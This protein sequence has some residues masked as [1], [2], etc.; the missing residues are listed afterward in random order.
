MSS[1]PNRA[2]AERLLAIAERLLRGQDFNGSRDFAVLAQENDPILDG[3]DQILAVADVLMASQKK[4][5]NHPDWYAILQV[6][7][8]SDD[9]EL[10]KRQYRRL[11]L[12]LHPDKNSFPFADSAFHLVSDAWKLLSDVQKKSI[13][14][15]E[16]GV[17]MFSKVDLVPVV[18]S[19]S[20]RD[21]FKKLPVRRGEKKKKNEEEEEEKKEKEK[22]KEQDTF[23]TVCPYCYNLYQYQKIYQDCC[24]KCQKCERAFHGVVIWPVPQMVPGKDAYYCCKAFFPFN[25]PPSADP[26]YQDPEA[27]KKMEATP[28]AAAPTKKRGRSRKR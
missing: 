3:S 5:N 12:L 9:L 15:N 21:S 22:E 8:R 18:E 7:R 24:L 11:T 13:Y 17:S 23:W 20:Y 16:I 2:E 10:I 19:N 4:V 1:N 25:F 6:N 26:N 28:A 14:D 27:A